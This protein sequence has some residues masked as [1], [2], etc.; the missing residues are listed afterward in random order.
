M[1]TSNI[2]QKNRKPSF[3]YLFVQL[4]LRGVFRHDSRDTSAP[5]TN[6]A[7]EHEHRSKNEPIRWPKTKTEQQEWKRREEWS[8]TY[9]K[10]RL[11]KRKKGEL[12]QRIFKEYLNV[13]ESPLIF[14]EKY[15]FLAVKK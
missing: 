1:K 12:T 15:D 8:L 7:T 14:F 13:K 11:M 3:P 4:N 5:R 2:L 10:K 6:S 9:T